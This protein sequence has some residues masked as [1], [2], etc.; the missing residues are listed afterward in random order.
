MN[1]LA[2]V[3]T[4][5]TGGP[6]APLSTFT[7]LFRR[8]FW[9][10][11]GGM[12]SAQLW[13]TGILLG[14]L[15]LSLLVGESFRLQFAGN[16][17]VGTVIQPALDRIGP[18]EMA[19][20]R[21]AMG[22]FLWAISGI[23]HVVL[24]FVVLFYCIG[25]LYDER[26]DR[27]ILFWKSLPATD[28]A[29]VLSKLVTATLVAPFLAFVATIILH[30]GV[31]VVIGLYVG[32]H[33][34]NP[35]PFLWQPGVI[36]QVWSQMLLMIPVHM[37]WAIPGIAWLLLASSWARRAPFVWALLIPV[38]CGMAYA[39]L[40]TALRLK[41]PSIWFWEHVVARIFLSPGSMLLR[42]WQWRGHPDIE[43]PFMGAVGW[44]RM[45]TI[46]SSPETWIGLVVG[47]VLLG[48]AIWLRRYRDDS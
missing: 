4:R 15:V 7:A 18:E 44:D 34:V 20:M 39:M 3:S 43:N 21:T 48:A 46:L 2:T 10:H 6:G 5:L 30:L 16:V 23:N 9:E 26:K 19:K 32:F 12:W 13:T 37:L 22:T 41:A 1:A 40:E 27:S 36:G 31:L 42:P 25:A 45:Q 28:T 38:L 35:M 17:H 14:F 47:A 8:E 33:G 24:Y 11:R 29:T